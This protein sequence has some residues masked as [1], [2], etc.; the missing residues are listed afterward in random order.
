MQSIPQYNVMALS[1][2]VCTNKMALSLQEKNRSEV[3][4]FVGQGLAARPTPDCSITSSRKFIRSV[5]LNQLFK[6]KVL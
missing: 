1:L 6:V 5:G 3:H 2:N 4:E